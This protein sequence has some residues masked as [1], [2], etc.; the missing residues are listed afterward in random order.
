MDWD[1][2]IVP[3][4]G[5]EFGETTSS[6]PARA[7]ITGIDVMNLAIPDKG[8]IGLSSGS[9]SHIPSN[10]THSRQP[11]EHVRASQITSPQTG[12]LFSQDTGKDGSAA[13]PMAFDREP[14]AKASDG[15]WLLR[16][17][18]MNVTLFQQGEKVGQLCS[19]ALSSSA[20][21][22]TSAS[23]SN[24][25]QTAVYDETFLLFFGFVR[26][27][28]QL[29][30]SV[31]DLELLS[32]Q[33]KMSSQPQNASSSSSGQISSLDPASVLITLSCYIRILEICQT[34]LG[35]MQ[36]KVATLDASPAISM[37]QLPTLVVS[38]GRLDDFP[39]LQLKLVLETYENLLT[40]MRALLVSQVIAAEGFGRERRSVEE[41][42]KTAWGKPNE[43]YGAREMAGETIHSLEDRI[44]KMIKQIRLNLANV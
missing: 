24:K 20:G 43:P 16:L 35:V 17:M 44:F 6:F 26:L 33:S 22:E 10:I 9:D 40:S 37:L 15:T 34:L 41:R 23:D 32:S 27:L 12:L 42:T 19:K 28:R 7:C 38:S 2:S 25:T 11:A 1:T 30:S 39:A 18:N 3:F 14:P 4:S 5:T 31:S 21:V 13:G 8:S 29:P 36:A